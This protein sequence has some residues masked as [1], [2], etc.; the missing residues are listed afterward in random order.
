MTTPYGKFKKEVAVSPKVEEVKEAVA[1]VPE[2]KEVKETV[3]KG[4]E[5]AD[6]YLESLFNG[7]QVL[8][9]GTEGIENAAKWLGENTDLRYHKVYSCSVMSEKPKELLL[10]GLSK[11]IAAKGK[12]KKNTILVGVAKYLPMLTAE[13]KDEM[14]P[15]NKREMERK[16]SLW[17]DEFKNMSVTMI[18]NVSLLARYH[19][20]NFKIPGPLISL[21]AL[22]GTDLDAPKYGKLSGKT[23]E[24]YKEGLAKYKSNWLS[25]TE[26]QKTKIQGSIG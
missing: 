8:T 4:E 7:F 15:S 1:R 25:L 26:A 2:V 24:I 22:Y 23:L 12:N 11:S 20:K 9:G 19:Y 13:Q 16:R 17:P 21:R 6:A 14:E 3:E 5:D 10:T 18:R